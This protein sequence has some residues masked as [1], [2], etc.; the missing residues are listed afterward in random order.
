MW[1]SL[2]LL[3]VPGAVAQE[4]DS[5]E[6]KFLRAVRSSDAATVKAML[7]AGFNANTKYRY[8]RMPLSFACDRGNIDVVR[9]LLDAGADVRAADSFYSATA[10]DW[11]LNKGHIEIV[12]LLLDRGAANSEQILMTGVNQNNA[13]LVKAS[14]AKGG[15]PPDSLTA[16][17]ARA[18][19]TNKPEIGDLLRSQGAKPPPQLDAAM[20]DKYAGTWRPATGSE[21]TLV[22]KDG[23]LEATGG[24]G[25]TRLLLALDETTFRPEQMGGITVKFSV[26]STGSV[27]G[28]T[29]KQGNNETS[30]KKVE[31]KP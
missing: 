19:R 30:Y 2:A 11:A 24:G 9:A 12:K 23:R 17:L 16:A 4:P 20:L 10:M 22:H 7:A 31:T 28:M 3:A 13:E 6:D 29:M 27:T 18:T 1:M 8:D 25:P 15:L 5:Q 14:L 21:I 26:D